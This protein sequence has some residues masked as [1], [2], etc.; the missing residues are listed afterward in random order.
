MQQKENEQLCY[1][2]KNTVSNI[3]LSWVCKWTSCMGGSFPAESVGCT[4]QEM[5][6]ISGKLHLLCYRGTKLQKESPRGSNTRKK[7][8]QKKYQEQKKKGQ[9]NEFNQ[10]VEVRAWSCTEA[11]WANNDPTSINFHCHSKLGELETEK[12]RHNCTTPCT[13]YVHVKDGLE[14]LMK[15]MQVQ[16][17]PGGNKE[18][19]QNQQGV[20]TSTGDSN[21]E[22]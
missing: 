8:H 7:T 22:Q 18:A 12:R 2:F 16:Q 4:G 21:K 10:D 19:Q 3:P 11:I 15:F 5:S 6:R 9:R 20:W 1:V 17:E 14:E 13:A